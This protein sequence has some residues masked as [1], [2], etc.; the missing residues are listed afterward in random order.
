MNYQKA[1]KFIVE[2]YICNAT[3]INYVIILLIFSNFF[4]HNNSNIFST[5]IASGIANN[6][7][8]TFLPEYC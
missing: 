6:I 8:N 3:L 1:I 2:F 7:G 4:A 5:G